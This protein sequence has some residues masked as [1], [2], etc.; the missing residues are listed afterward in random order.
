MLGAWQFL[1]LELLVDRRV[2]IPRPETELV[3]Q[4]ALDEAARLGLRRGS[5]DHWD[6]VGTDVVVD[7]GTGSGALALAL[8]TELPDAEVWAVD[9]SEDALRVARANVAGIGGAAATRVRVAQG[10]W[11]DALP[12]E[13]RGTLR[14]V[15]SNPPYIAEHEVDAAPSRDRVGAVRRAGERADRARSH[16]GG[17]HRRDRV[18]RS[19]AAAR[20]CASSE[21][22]KATTRSRLHAPPASPTCRSSATSPVATA[23]S[24]YEPESRIPTRGSVSAWP[25]TSTSTRC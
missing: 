3:A 2:L 22:T 20:W 10:S 16:R 25:M 13:L 11:Y 7:L 19:R 17:G 8:A 24:S 4:I 1:G 15:V 18:A 23:C 5:A 14:L 9:T 6:V 12:A 21:R